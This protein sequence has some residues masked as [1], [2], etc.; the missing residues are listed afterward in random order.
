M[1]TA[2]PRRARPPRPV[3]V[4]RT[5]AYARDVD[6]GAAVAGQLVRGACRRHLRDLIDGDSRGLTFDVEAAERAINFFRFVNHSKGEWSGRAVQLEPWECFIV[7]SLFGWKRADGTRRFRT[8]Y[9]EVARKNGKSLLGAGVGLLLAFFDNE[10]GAEVYCAAT[11][12]D[13][14]KIVWGEARTMVR[15]SPSLRDR[16]TTLV[17]NLHMERTNSKF[18]PLGADAD[19]MDGLNMHGAIIDE[20]HAH[21]TRAV[22]DVLE[23]ATAARRQPLTFVI[24]T[25]GFDRNTVCWEQ[26]SYGVRVV[27]GA[28]DDDAFFAY[29]ATLDACDTCRAAGKLQPST[30]CGDCDD[31]RD[32][33]V[34]AKAN[35]NLG[36]SV[37]V[38]D[39]ARKVDKAKAVPGQ[40][41]AVLRLHMNIWTE[42]ASRWLSVEAWDECAGVR[43]VGDLAAVRDQ[44]ARMTEECEGLPCFAGLD[45]SSKSDVTALVLWVPH[46]DGP[47]DILAYF[48]VPE[49]AV[50]ER[51][52]AGVPYDV[53]VREGF[54][55]ECDGNVIDYDAIRDFIRDEIAP[56]FEVAEIGYDQWS[57]TQL[58]LQLQ[59]EGATVV[60]VSQTFSGLNEACK[61]VES[62]VSARTFRHGG[63]PVLR[64]M[65]SNVTVERDAT[66][67]MRP[68]KTKSQE[69]IDGISAMC[70][71]A[72]R[73]ILAPTDSG[74]DVWFA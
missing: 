58:A 32:P 65:M 71:A 13:Q 30:D 47:V 37:K 57:A 34:W 63:H 22:W 50:V 56:R 1:P 62:R 44:I 14:A 61:E 72:A 49:T 48:W 2:T 9:V 5:T 55:F 24:T 54:M 43:D 35:P 36:V 6:D 73:A 3:D 40:V 39:I 15:R 45:L 19:S 4:D 20:L 21:K 66:N 59:A 60:P 46:D 38:E 25:A 52:R 18:E 33:D 11:K 23:T 42:A 70:D 64:W 67:R 41:N 28:F 29:I 8:G 7:G 10:P 27:D 68:S 74:V 51:S 26:H 17:G 53:W 69:K 12:R 16:I 31:W